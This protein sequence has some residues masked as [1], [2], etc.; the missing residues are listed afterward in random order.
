MVPSSNLRD[1][2]MKTPVCPLLVAL[3]AILAGSCSRYAPPVA[4]AAGTP[5]GDAP[6]LKREIRVTGL[7]QAVHASKVLVPQI[8]G[9]GGPMTLTK[10]IGNGSRVKK[11]DLI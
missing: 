5:P 11:D 2:T 4:H 1:P 7:I 3:T 9:Q 10:L 6:R 8:S